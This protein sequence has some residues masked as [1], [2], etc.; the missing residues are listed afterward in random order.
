M[1]TTPRWRGGGVISGGDE[2]AGRDAVERLV[3]WSTRAKSKGLVVAFRRNERTSVPVQGGPRTS[4]S[5]ESRHGRAGEEGSA[6]VPQ[7][8]WGRSNISQKAAAV[9]LS[10][11]SSG[12]PDLLFPC[13]G[14]QL[15]GSWKKGH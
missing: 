2:F 4:A 15:C 10:L 9:L 3:M 5:W 12:H 6:E 8:Y 13:V 7:G 14:C 1:R 11:L